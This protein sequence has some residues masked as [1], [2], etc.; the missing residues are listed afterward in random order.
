MYSRAVNCN[1]TATIAYT[2]VL[3]YHKRNKKGRRKRRCESSIYIFGAAGSSS[4]M[5]SMY[6]LVLS[7]RKILM[8]V[9]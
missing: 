4:I 9:G 8:P 5:V 6:I 3:L 2:F 7:D 1:V